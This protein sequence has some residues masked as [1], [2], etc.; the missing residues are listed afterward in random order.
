MLI[1]LIVVI[2]IFLRV[3][4]V[5][6]K[7]VGEVNRDDI[8]PGVDGLHL[9]HYLLD[10]ALRSFHSLLAIRDQEQALAVLSG[11]TKSVHHIE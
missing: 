7:L 11:A 1:L 5:L 8:E 2:T 6:P 10:S 4:V 3:I 9:V